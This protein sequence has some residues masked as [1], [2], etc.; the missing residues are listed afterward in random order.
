LLPD[1]SDH[2]G[3]KKNKKRIES[4]SREIFTIAAVGNKYPHPRSLSGPDT[5]KGG[6]EGERAKKRHTGLT[7]GVAVDFQAAQHK[8]ADKGGDTGGSAVPAVFSSSGH[9]K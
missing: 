1:R 8:K 4:E 7:K 6:R 5:Q 2:Q 3:G 9:K